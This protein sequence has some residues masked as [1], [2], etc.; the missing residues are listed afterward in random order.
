MNRRYYDACLGARSTGAT[1]GPVFAAG[2]RKP[3]TMGRCAPAPSAAA[4]STTSAS[5]NG[6]GVP[7][8]ATWPMRRASSLQPRMRRHPQTSQS[9][10][11]GR[12]TRTRQVAAG[13]SQHSVPSAGTTRPPDITSVTNSA[14]QHGIKL[15]VPAARSH[16][17]QVRRIYYAQTNI[18]DA[19]RINCRNEYGDG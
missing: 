12:P 19:P 3:A 9:K 2:R 7:L 6:Q 11:T 5:I 1:N 18:E 4:G 8:T 16:R 15:A 14:A 17:R 13:D 10:V